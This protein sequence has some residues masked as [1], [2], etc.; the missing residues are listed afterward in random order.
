MFA[1]HIDPSASD[2]LR[3]R[4]H[5]STYRSLQHH[6]TVGIGLMRGEASG[7]VIRCVHDPR[8]D[9]DREP[10]AGCQEVMHQVIK[11]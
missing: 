7:L 10:S 5:E 6:E 1:T 2:G 4:C 9:E 3:V 8:E 11:R